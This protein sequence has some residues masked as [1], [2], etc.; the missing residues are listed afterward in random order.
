MAIRN[1]KV[2]DCV[3]FLVMV[4]VQVCYAGMNITSKVALESGMNPLVLVAYRQIF[5]TMA[6]GPFSYIMEWKTM[7]KITFPIL[8]QIFLC[9]LTG[10]VANQVF[11]FLGLKYSSAIIASA[12]SN[13]LP[14]V[15]FLLAVIFRQESAEIRKKSGIAKIVGTI[16]CVG[17][18]MMLSFYQGKVIGLG[19]PNMNW[20]Y[21]QKVRESTT[22]N[23]VNSNPLLGPIFIILSTVGW[24]AWFIIQA[25]MSEKFPAPY[26]STTLMCFMATVECGAIGF[27]LEHKISAWSLRNDTR[28][29]A[30]LYAG[31]M[32]SAI[33]FFLTSWSIQRKGPLYVSVF[34]PLLLIIVAILSWALLKE[35][36][37]IGTVLGSTFI[38]AGLY[39]VLWGKGKEMERIQE[40]MTIAEDAIKASKAN[41]DKINEDLELQI[42]MK[43]YVQYCSNGCNHIDEEAI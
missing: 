19:E 26:T 6:I 28:L 10:A 7:P 21:L 27:V 4:F 35:K 15:T 18:A 39:A 17:G 36:I 22:S 40:I 32:G 16:L 42:Q 31:I 8:F 2:G 1:T 33:A 25:G 9:S 13:I 23:T 11:Y 37:Y 30:S 24:A 14:A 29:V 43:P 5:A 38:I 41:H 34:S 12:L 3:P 20:S